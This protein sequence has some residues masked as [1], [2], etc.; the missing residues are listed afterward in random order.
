[1]L[2]LPLAIRTFMMLN[3]TRFTFDMRLSERFHVQMVERKAAQ[4]RE[5]SAAAR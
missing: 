2:R 5:T 4:I 3:L 1:M